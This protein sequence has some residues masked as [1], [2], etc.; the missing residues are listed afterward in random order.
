[1]FVTE[2]LTKT[3]SG[4]VSHKCILLRE[5]F[6]EKGGRPKSRTLANLTHCKPNE[7]AAIKLALEYKDDL[8]AL[9][10]CDSVELKEGM[11]VGTIW[12]V[13]ETARKLGIEKALGMERQGKLALWQ[14]MARVID[15][16]SRLSAV[17][18]AQ[19]HAAC[20][21]LGLRKGFNEDEL[22]RNLGWLKENQ[23]EIEKK[24]FH[25]YHKKNRPELF[26]YDVTSSY[27]EGCQNELAE[28][29][30]NRDRK[31]GKKQ[32]VVGLLCDGSLHRQH[33]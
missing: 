20:D 30:Y 21:V 28:W 17:R 10:S 19:V 29:G 14:V 26:L 9:K 1:M 22:Y 12:L 8:T 3:K 27:F 11:S 24:L 5:S 33:P 2:V 25:A 13:Y 31:S 23:Q 16:G 15:Q 18:L 6:R 7:I 4:K 32:V